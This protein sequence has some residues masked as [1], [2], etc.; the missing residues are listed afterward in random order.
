MKRYRIASVLFVVCILF[1]F[2]FSN[3]FAAEKKA[4][5]MDH[6]GF[7]EEDFQNGPDVKALIEKMRV[8][9]G[10]PSPKEAKEKYG[11]KA[12]SSLERE[13]E[14]V[15]SFLDS[16]AETLSEK[17]QDDRLVGRSTESGT[18][19]TCTCA[20]V[21]S[22]MVC[23]GGPGTWTWDN[24]Q[25]TCPGNISR[26]LIIE[27]GCY[28]TINGCQ[29]SI[30]D[31]ILIYDN[32]TMDMNWSLIAVG[33]RV[34]VEGSSFYGFDSYFGVSTRVY[35][36][37][38]GVTSS[39]VDFENVEVL[40]YGAYA[41]PRILVEDSSSLKLQ[42]DDANPPVHNYNMA[43]SC[44][45][46]WDDNYM[47]RIQEDSDL[48][49]ELTDVSNAAKLMYFNGTGEVR[50]V[51]NSFFNPVSRGIWIYGNTEA[52]RIY[53]EDNL[54]SFASVDEDP[55][56]YSYYAIRVESCSNV[57]DSDPFI[58]E[59]NVFSNASTED[60]LWEKVID[61]KNNTADGL[62]QY[63][64]MNGFENNGISSIYNSTYSAYGEVNITGNII[65]CLEMTNVFSDYDAG[66]YIDNEEDVYLYS[67]WVWNAE[68]ANMRGVCMLIQNS[69][70]VEIEGIL[71]GIPDYPDL[72]DCGTGIVANWTDSLNIHH[73]DYGMAD[74]PTSE[75]ACF[76]YSLDGDNT[77][78]RNNELISDPNVISSTSIS[79]TYGEE[80]VLEDNVIENWITG[81]SI[82]LVE[83][84]RIYRNT[85]SSLSTG[86]SIVNSSS[87]MTNH[88]R[89]NT[90]T[91]NNVG[92]RAA[93]YDDLANS[94]VLGGDYNNRQANY[95]K[96]PYDPY[97]YHVALTEHGSCG[98]FEC[99]DY[100]TH[101]MAP[102]NFFT[103]DGTTGLTDGYVRKGYEAECSDNI[104]VVNSI[105]GTWNSA[106][107][108]ADCSSQ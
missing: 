41:Y 53:I 23:S 100:F 79:K 64:V 43:V 36:Y 29:I 44:Y 32:S 76:L 83:E 82:D 28:L 49:M 54:F 93:Y 80:M 33:D 99:C 87:S 56:V 59:S 63:N 75:H 21:G 106:T 84:F 38:N 1:S 27:D 55:L 73:I 17:M 57:V 13:S 88:F 107:Y 52:D 97:N 60:V 70:S 9:K 65:G 47:F 66:I 72:W 34:N 86:V 37:G 81:I 77:Y 8:K 90:I 35:A 45:T 94:F 7:S 26:D 91:A 96:V 102:N 50:I 48:D 15:P 10:W 71:D 11:Y 89:C 2:T 62:V 40:F 20:T 85:I 95:I 39:T 101:W 58:I 105:S 98:T 30:G 3:G 19:S 68:K 18:R 61:L 67:N 108:Q 16:E 24:S 25:S 74:Y 4:N 104:T 103:N 12:T 46:P 14:N 51:E 31:D 6:F 5:P 92:V 42:G 69:D 22:D 78:I